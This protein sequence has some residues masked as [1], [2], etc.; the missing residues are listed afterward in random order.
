MQISVLLAGSCPLKNQGIY[1]NIETAN[2]LTVVETTQELD[3]LPDLYTLHQPD[4]LLVILDGWEEQFTSVVQQLPTTNIVVLSSQNRQSC[5]TLI[6]NG[7]ING[8]LPETASSELLSQAI[9]AVANGNVWFSQSL[10]KQILHPVPPSRKAQYSLTTQELTMLRL[11]MQDKTNQY[12]GQAMDVGERTVCDRLSTIY[13]KLGVA[14][15]L[16]A[17]LKAE[18]LGLVDE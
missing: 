15:R 6:H 18:R 11:I 1:F 14:S 10:F 5:H 2:N 4:L 16:A 7:V 17:A 3:Q 9:Y 8:C 12:I 13:E